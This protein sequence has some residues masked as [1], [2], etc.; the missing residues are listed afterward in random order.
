MLGFISFIFPSFISLK[1]ELHFLEKKLNGIQFLTSFSIYCL[2]NNMITLGIFK[3]IFNSFYEIEKNINL[4]SG[5]AFK[6]MAVAIIVAI[7]L[8]II[9][10]FLE[11][12]IEVKIEK[13]K[14]G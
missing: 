10:V 6:Y 9:E 7:I 3:L 1:L 5:I 4:Y 8:G 2:I 12:N 11:K 14:K 13:I